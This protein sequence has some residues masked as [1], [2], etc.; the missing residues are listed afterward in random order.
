MLEKQQV[1]SLKNIFGTSLSAAK[2]RKKANLGTLTS[3]REEIVIRFAKKSL[4]TPRSAHWFNER[5]KPIYARRAGVNYPRYRE[6]TVRT[7]R[8]RCSPKNYIVRKVNENS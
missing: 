3:R 1:Q 5:P 4:N 8:H 2:L 7:D 6:E